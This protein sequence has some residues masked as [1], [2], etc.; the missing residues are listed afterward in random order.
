MAIK[1]ILFKTNMV[2]ALLAGR[3]TVT[4]RIIKSRHKSGLF[5]VCKRKT[6][7]TITEISSLDWDAMPM[8]DCANDIQ[9][10]YQVGDVLWVRETYNYNPA[11]NKFQYKA[12]YDT[13]AKGTRFW[14]PSIFMPR[15]AARFF[16]E[17]TAVRVER[18]QDITEADAIREGIES[19]RPVPGD[20]PTQTI[21][22]NYLTNKYT[23]VFPVVS[24]M[25]LWESING[26]GSWEANP[27]VWV[28]EFKPVEKPENF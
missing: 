16:L 24:F 11:T 15:A 19:F 3:K 17:V 4:R 28:Y 22:K 23:E 7:D 26:K 27:W 8:N 10:K 9:P 6:D 5:R 2:Q 14:K 20:G 13:P 18:L 21:Y 12:D 1:E 25:T